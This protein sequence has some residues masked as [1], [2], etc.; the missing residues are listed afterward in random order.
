MDLNSVEQLVVTEFIISSEFRLAPGEVD[1]VCF[2]FSMKSD[3]QRSSSEVVA[4][5]ST[6]QFVSTGHCSA[7]ACI[8]QRK[9][10]CPKSIRFVEGQ[11]CVALF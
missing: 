1:N 9:H 3:Q 7:M 4:D 5:R 6:T 10:Q 8:D 2:R 11:L